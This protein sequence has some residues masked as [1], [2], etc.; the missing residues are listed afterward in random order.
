MHRGVVQIVDLRG[1]RQDD[2]LRPAQLQQQVLR[3]V[4][5]EPRHDGSRCEPD[6]G[7]QQP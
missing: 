2:L 7:V 4:E 5:V 3:S 1:A 6:Q